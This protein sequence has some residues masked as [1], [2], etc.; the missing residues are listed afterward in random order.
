[1]FS[2]EKNNNNLQLSPQGLGSLTPLEPV[3]DE[4]TPEYAAALT[5]A[6]SSTVATATALQVATVFSLWLK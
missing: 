5:P 1:M 3:A 6:A 2:T 4:A